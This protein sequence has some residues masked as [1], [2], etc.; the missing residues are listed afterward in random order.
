[1][2]WF[3]GLGGAIRDD[4]SL[5]N[6]VLELSSGRVVGKTRAVA[7]FASADEESKTDGREGRILFRK[8]CI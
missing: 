4:C 3:V 5:R 8:E 2:R 7:E 6:A 1:M